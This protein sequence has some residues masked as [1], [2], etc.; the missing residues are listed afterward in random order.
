M[1]SS[2]SYIPKCV[3]RPDLGADSGGTW[4]LIPE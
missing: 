1:L 4:A 3:F 2:M